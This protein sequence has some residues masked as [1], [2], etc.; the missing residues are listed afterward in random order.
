MQPGAQS[1][2]HACEDR[3]QYW[4][5]GADG[6]AN[7]VGP[8]TSL[9]LIQPGEYLLQTKDGLGQL[10]ASLTPEM[11][12]EFC[13]LGGVI[14]TNQ[15]RA[16]SPTPP[17]TWGFEKM[18]QGIFLWL[19]NAGRVK[20]IGPI[21]S[22]E[23]LGDDRYCL[24]TTA[25]R[26]TIRLSTGNL[27]TF[28]ELGGLDVKQVETRDQL[29]LGTRWGALWEKWVGFSIPKSVCDSGPEALKPLRWC[30]LGRHVKIG[31]LKIENPLTYFSQGMPEGN[32]PSCIDITLPVGKPVAEPPGAL[33]YW[34]NYRG[35]SPD[36]RASSKISYK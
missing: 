28:Q 3:I 18:E 26:H 35:I 34:P 4:F 12:R 9:K 31:A 33:G 15:I 21:I 30:D 27:A 17:P 16:Q 23:H 2:F 10:R 7:I 8:V 29:S 19:L 32:E 25:A 5:M 6:V 20:H 22:L 11:T 36:Q 1:G 24:V 13:R 14:Q